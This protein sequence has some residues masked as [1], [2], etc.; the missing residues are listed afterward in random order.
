VISAFSKEASFLEAKIPLPCVK[1]TK[2]NDSM[3][4]YLKV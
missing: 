3:N 1:N 4:L 2:L